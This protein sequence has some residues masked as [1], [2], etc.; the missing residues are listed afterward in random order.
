M[1]RLYIVRVSW[2]F[3]PHGVNFPSKILAAAQKH[4]ALRVVHDE[5]GNPTYAPDAARLYGN[6]CGRDATA[7][8]I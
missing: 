5:F 6:W 1:E 8:I 7:S 4:G 3:G 2:L